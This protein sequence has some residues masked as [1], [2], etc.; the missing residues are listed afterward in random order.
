[1]KHNYVVLHRYPKN[2]KF[3]ESSFVPEKGEDPFPGHEGM[4]DSL[5]Q[6]TGQKIIGVI[7]ATMLENIAWTRREEQEAGPEQTVVIYDLVITYLNS[8]Q[9]SDGHLQIQSMNL[10]SGSGFVNNVGNRFHSKSLQATMM[11]NVVNGICKAIM[12]TYESNG[13]SVVHY[14]PPF[15]LGD[16]QLVSTTNPYFDAAGEKGEG[17]EEVFEEMI[18]GADFS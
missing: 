14:Y 8:S 5:E 3:E 6:Q 13:Q 11:N 1:M 17:L 4:F 9:V 2:Q 15:D 18:K 16:I 7:N 12:K 10:F